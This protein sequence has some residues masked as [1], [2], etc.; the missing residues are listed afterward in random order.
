MAIV[1]SR[2]KMNKANLLALD[3]SIFGSFNSD[4]KVSLGHA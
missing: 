2:E 1:L 3:K 4:V